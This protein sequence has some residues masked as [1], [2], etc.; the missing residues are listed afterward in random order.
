MIICKARKYVEVVL[1]CAC[2]Y[3]ARKHFVE[4]PA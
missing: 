4:V 3:T 1:A 2:I